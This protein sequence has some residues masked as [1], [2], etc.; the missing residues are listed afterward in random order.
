MD[1]KSRRTGKKA[2]GTLVEAFSIRVIESG[3]PLDGSNQISSLFVYANRANVP[4]YMVK[5]ESPTGS[6]QTIS[7]VHDWS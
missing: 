3:C 2:N 5:G 6:F 4:D 1:V 7:A